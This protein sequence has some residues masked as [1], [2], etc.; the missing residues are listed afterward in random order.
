MFPIL[1][2]AGVI[3]LAVWIPAYWHAWGWRNFLHFCDVAVF[4]SCVGFWTRG[5]LLLSSQAL[6]SIIP[7]A[8]W[9]LDA[10]WR[11]FTTRGLFGGTEYMWDTKVALWIRLLS[12]FHVVLP[13][14]LIYAAVKAGYDGRG[15][16]LQMGICAVLLVISRFFSPQ[17]NLNY[18]FQEPLLHRSF[19][20]AVLHLAAVFAFITVIFYLPVHALFARCSERVRTSGS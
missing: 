2:W 8:V 10:A 9:C 14:L 20:P 13:C 4:L 5:S 16:G 7:D 6:A 17:L 11:V 18:A 3:W 12:L 19:H 1:R 15:L